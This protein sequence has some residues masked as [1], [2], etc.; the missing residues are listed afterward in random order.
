LT[1]RVRSVQAFTETRKLATAVMRDSATDEK[2]GNSATADLVDE[3][4]FWLLRFP[5]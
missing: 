3:L 1:D 5:T 2:D 4:L